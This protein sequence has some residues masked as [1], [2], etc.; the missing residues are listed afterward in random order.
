MIF[1]I[2]ISEDNAYAWTKLEPKF[3][4]NASAPGHGIRFIS[5]DHLIVIQANEVYTFHL[6]KHYWSKCE[7]QKI[8]N[9]NIR[10]GFYYVRPGLA[11][12]FQWNSRAGIDFYPIPVFVT[13]ELGKNGAPTNFCQKAQEIDC[14]ALKSLK[15]V[16]SVHADETSFY[17]VGSDDEEISNRLLFLIDLETFQISEKRS[18]EKFPC[19]PNSSIKVLYERKL[20]VLAKEGENLDFWCLHID[21][22]KWEKL[23]SPVPSKFV[24]Q[25]FSEKI[26][27]R[28]VK[29]NEVLFGENKDTGTDFAILSYDFKRNH[30]TNGFL[31]QDIPQTQDVFSSKSFFIYQD[32]IISFCDG[33]VYSIKNP[34]ESEKIE[35]KQTKEN[36]QRLLADKNTADIVFK[37]EDQEFPAHKNILSFRSPYF[38]N[39][40]SSNMIE[41]HSNVIS[42]ENVKAKVFKALLKYIYVED[43]EIEDEILEDLFKLSH[44]YNM[45]KLNKDCQ[46]M[47][48]KK[49]SIENAVDYINLAEQYEAER[50]RKACLNF[51]ADNLKEIIRTQNFKALDNETIIDVI[52]LSNCCRCHP[53][54]G[55]AEFE[56]DL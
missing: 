2:A 13:W 6:E 10:Y 36:V 49:I 22:M 40:F 45:T 41:S 20:F 52:E 8:E 44:E 1:H 42:I 26:P 11:V 39:A 18:G 30:W 29:D 53:S 25:V 55:E 37:V 23:K 47:I 24:S 3:Y 7:I 38:K 32:S 28:M 4:N 35:K 50:L 16:S 43:F 9:Q 12:D 5:L 15:Y 34:F 14:S 17:I 27:Y 48:F 54:K 31:L 46:K 21:E 33:K 19:C 51:I 56:Y